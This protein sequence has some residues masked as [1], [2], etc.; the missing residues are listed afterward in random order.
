MAKTSI[1]YSVG[2]PDFR[3]LQAHMAKRLYARNRGAYGR[4]LIGVVFCALF[5][6]LAIVVNIHPRLAF[7]LL[8]V[9]Y[10]LSTYL[11]LIL[12]LVLAIVSLLP[13]VRLR[14]TMLRS[15]VTDDGPLLGR[16]RLSIEEDGLVFDRVLVASRYKWKAFQGVE[17]AKG[18][19][20]L[21]VDN[22]I[23][24]I[25]PAATFE[26]DTARYE[27]AALLSRRIEDSRRGDTA[28]THS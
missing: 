28:S 18:A 15:Q 10:P 22:G 20:I 5:L 3:F 21:P 14:L 26:S 6:T 9:G 27:F 17:I 23:G 25:V 16:T 8:P 4:A 13:A 24:L 7:Y 2:F 19:L 12:F 1:D 11:A